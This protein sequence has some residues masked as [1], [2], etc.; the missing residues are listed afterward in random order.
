M[1]KYT[2]IYSFANAGGDI[3]VTAK[4]D[5]DALEEGE[6]LMLEIAHELDEMDYTVMR[7]AQAIAIA[8]MQERFDTETEP[9]GTPWVA[10]DPNYL[11]SKLAAGFPPDILHRTGD[12][13]RAA[14]NPDTWL[15]ADNELM[16]DA[17]ALPSY[18]IIHQ[19]G[20]SPENAGYRTAAMENEKFTRAPGEKRTRNFELGKGNALPARPFIGLSEVADANLWRLFDTWFYALGEEEGGLGHTGEAP[21][22]HPSGRVQ[23]RQAGRFGPN[24]F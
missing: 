18:G 8:D 17:G 6:T 2:G 4:A 13:E 10:L 5:I 7:G 12:L 3:I 9:D 15:I 19:V 21:I 23:T 24:L 20:S 1:P 22:F 16:F 11:R 14:T